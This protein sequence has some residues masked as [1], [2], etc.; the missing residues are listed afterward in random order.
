MFK[1]TN[2]EQLLK[3]FSFFEFSC[4]FKNVVIFLGLFIVIVSVLSILFF[5]RPKSPDK[6]DNECCLI[7][8]PR[9]FFNRD[10]EPVFN[11]LCPVHKFCVWDFVDSIPKCE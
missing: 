10:C 3:M 5:F 6:A 11:N 8:N 4:S 2:S 9:K 1:L 7:E